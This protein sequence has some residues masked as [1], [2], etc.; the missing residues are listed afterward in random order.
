MRL[1]LSFSNFWDDFNPQE[2]IF[3][4]LLRDQLGHSISYNF[5]SA[6][7]SIHFYSAFPYIQEKSHLDKSVNQ[8]WLY[9]GEN[10]RPRCDIYDFS[11]SFDLLNNSKHQRLPLWLLYLDWFDRQNNYPHND[12]ENINP[13]YITQGRDPRELILDRSLCAVISNPVR[14]RIKA[15]K[16]LSKGRRS[17]GFGR[18]FNKRIKDKFELSNKFTFQ[19]CFENSLYPGYVSEKL[20]QAYVSKMIPV[21]WGSSLAS[22]DFNPRAF[23]NASDFNSVKDLGKF[24]NEVTERELMEIYSQPLLNHLPKF[25]HLLTAMEARLVS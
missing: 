17:V 20:L 11:L 21:Y 24:L 10:V 7:L 8:N 2:N 1:A 25:S 12:R 23:I 22:H 14:H 4:Y 16:I 5:H 13:R 15:F 9:L 3:I 6:E 19:F 18:A